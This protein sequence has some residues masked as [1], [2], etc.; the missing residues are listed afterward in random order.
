MKKKLS[1]ELFRNDKGLIDVEKSTKAFEEAC[2]E[3]KTTEDKVFAEVAPA[4]NGVF[5]KWPDTT[6][7]MKAVV[8]FA[9]PSDMNPNAHQAFAEKVEAYI[10]AHEGSLFTI[11][12]GVGISRIKDDGTTPA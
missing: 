9:T 6:L 4:V 1:V 8:S 12:R 10:H 3:M 5:E 7:N 11:K 2:A